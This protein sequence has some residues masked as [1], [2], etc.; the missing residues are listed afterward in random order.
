MGTRLVGKVAIVT[1]AS[2]GQ[3]AATATLFASE[4]ARIM[5]A[6]VSAPDPS[7]MNSLDGSALF[8]RQDVSDAAGWRDLVA[9]TQAGSTS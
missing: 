5:L 1:G 9:A 7:L 6:D 8:M 4:G 2:R 3:G